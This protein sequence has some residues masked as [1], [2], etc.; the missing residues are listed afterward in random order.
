MSN[1]SSVPRAKAAIL[2]MVQGTL[3]GLNT[4]GAITWAHPGGDPPKEMVFL[5]D[6]EFDDEQTAAMR[7]APR[8]QDETYSVPVW[9]SILAEGNDP[10]SAEER[11]WEIVGAVENV[12]RADQSLGG[13]TGLHWALVNGKTPRNIMTD[14]GWAAECMVRVK[15]HART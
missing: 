12:I 15:C 10:Q 13:M 6:V 3:T 2:A 14:Q 4:A 5:S 7:T 1:V 9:V 8:Y 11:M